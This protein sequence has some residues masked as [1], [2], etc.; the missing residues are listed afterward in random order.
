MPDDSFTEVTT[1]SWL[2]RLGNSVKGILIGLILFVA[3]VPLLFW[4]EGRA[5]ERTRSLE[6]GEG[7]V[8]SVSSAEVDVGKEGALVHTSGRAVPV[9]ETRDPLFGIGGKVIKLSRK[10]EMYQWS[11]ESHSEERKKL[12]GGTETT[13]TYSYSRT[14]SEKPIDSARFKKPQGHV[15]PSGMPYRSK[16]WVADEVKLG[17]YTLPR[18]LAGAIGG[19]RSL[20]VTSEDLQGPSEGED[21]RIRAGS[22][23]LGAEPSAPQ[24]GDVRIGF[25]VVEPTDVSLVARQVGSTFEPYHAKA[26][27]DIRWLENGIH[28]AESMFESAHRSNSMLTW[29]LRFAGLIMMTIGLSLVLKPLSV[30]ADVLPILGDILEAGTGLVA[31]LIS[32]ALALVTIAVAWVFYRPDLGIAL[33]AVAGGAI[34][35]TRGRIKTAKAA[36]PTALGDAASSGRTR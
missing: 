12:G 3:A 2:G 26:G 23:Y 20:P 27:S 34:W 10:V 11:E 13:T 24:V 25:S 8:V 32:L 33:L 17:A 21:L 16:S 14:W 1:Q 19:D 29:I 4:N 7:I 9:G 6:E 30:V 15:N 31:F 22:F 5:V 35:L 36:R 28:S 18:Y